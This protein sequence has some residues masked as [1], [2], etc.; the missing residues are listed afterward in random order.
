MMY[1]MREKKQIKSDI[2]YKIV[3]T[4]L[5]VKKS[6]NTSC[7]RQLCLSTYVYMFC[8]GDMWVYELNQ[9]VIAIDGVGFTVKSRTMNTTWQKLYSDGWNRTSNLV[10]CAGVTATPRNRVKT[11]RR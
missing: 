6:F 10:Y 7:V 11:L 9:P 4:I 8:G 5:F 2:K 3:N 1:F